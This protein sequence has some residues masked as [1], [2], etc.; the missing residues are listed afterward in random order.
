M[1][2]TTSQPTKP[3]TPWQRIRSALVTLNSAGPQLCRMLVARHGS[4]KVAAEKCGISTVHFCNVKNGHSNAS[5]EML[6]RM[7]FEMEATHA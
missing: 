4:G 3:L 5:L 2:V 6:Q 7:C 1:S